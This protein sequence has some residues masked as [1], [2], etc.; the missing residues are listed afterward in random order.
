LCL[1]I[2]VLPIL[3]AKFGLVTAILLEGILISGMALYYLR[4]IMLSRT[5]K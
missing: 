4:G 5:K 3:Y 1:L 2:I